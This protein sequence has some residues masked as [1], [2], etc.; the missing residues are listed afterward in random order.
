MK[1]LRK[2]LELIEVVY[3]NDNKKATMTFLDV[4]NGEVLD[5]NFNKQSYDNDK[6]VDDPEKEKRVDEWCEE[7]FGTTFDKLGEQVGVRKDVYRYDRFNSLWETKIT[8]KFSLDDKGKII[9][10]EISRIEDD[11]KGIHI[12]FEHEEKEYV[13]K[14][15]YSDYV[16]SVRSWF[17]NPQKKLRQEAKF[18]DMFGV[19]VEEAEKIVGCPIMVEVKVAFKKHPYAEIKKP[20]WA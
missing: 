7:Y 9:Q 6:F 2:D 10:T 11:G 13:S 4:E 15:M 17:T 18:L 8:E 16:E 14:M 5:V 3:N 12:Y 19:P 20:N 1:N